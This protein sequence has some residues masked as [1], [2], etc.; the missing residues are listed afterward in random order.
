MRTYR[1]PNTSFNVSIVGYGC[2]TI[3]GRWDNSP[4]TTE[5]RAKA[6]RAVMTAFENGITIFD[7]ADIYCR[8]NRKPYSAKFYGNI[9]A[10]VRKLFFNQNVVF[11]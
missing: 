3:G 5:D 9:P 11:V 6:T 2:M 4:L 7:H 8:G 10:C 1:I